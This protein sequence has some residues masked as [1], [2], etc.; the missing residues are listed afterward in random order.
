MSTSWLKRQQISAV[1][2]VKLVVTLVKYMPQVWTNYKRKSTVGWSIGQILLDVVGGVLSIAQLV[3]DSSLQGDWSGILGNPVKF[4]LGNVSIF[5]DVIFMVQHYILYRVTGKSKDDE[6]S[7][8]VER[9][10]LLSS[11][12]EDGVPK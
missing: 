12:E 5:F 9:R 4:G 6:D 8:D 10:G 2:Y 1:G 7:N 11:D 3:I